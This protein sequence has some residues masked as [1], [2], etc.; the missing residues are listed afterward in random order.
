MSPIEDD[1]V[2]CGAPFFSGPLERERRGWRASGEG[3]KERVFEPL[4]TE[5][6]GLFRQEIYIP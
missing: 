3:N 6:M 1:A 4:F 5:T 2:V